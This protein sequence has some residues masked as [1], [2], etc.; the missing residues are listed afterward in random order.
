[1]SVFHTVLYKANAESFPLLQLKMAFFFTELNLNVNLLKS[2]K[3]LCIFE[4][5]IR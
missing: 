4:I 1:M 3:F 2:P 5:L